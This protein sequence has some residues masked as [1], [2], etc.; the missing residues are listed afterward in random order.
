MGSMGCHAVHLAQPHRADLTVQQE[1]M[2]SWGVPRPSV[3]LTRNSAGLRGRLPMIRHAETCLATT[4]IKQRPLYLSTLYNPA[5]T[6]AGTRK[7]LCGI[8]A[9]CLLV[10]LA[11]SFVD[12]VIAQL[13]AWTIATFDSCRWRTGSCTH[14]NWMI[15][16]LHRYNHAAS[17]GQYEVQTLHP[18]L[19]WWKC[20]CTSVQ[21]ASRR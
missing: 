16:S 7:H 15:L 19:F 9:C 1:L 17:E 2:S 5:S 10:N 20:K 3:Q 11:R 14:G 12:A 4:D 13:A 21:L 6:W 8:F 18:G